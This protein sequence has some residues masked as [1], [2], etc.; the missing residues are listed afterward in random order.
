MMV[1]V[2]MMTTMTKG[3]EP[4]KYALTY[5]A[6][7]GDNANF[8]PLQ[9][10]PSLIAMQPFRGLIFTGSFLT[11]NCVFLSY[12][13]FFPLTI[14]NFQ[15]FLLMKVLRMPSVLSPLPIMSVSIPNYLLAFI[16]DSYF[17][18]FIPSVAS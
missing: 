17:A 4:H 5:L 7:S 16:K 14:Q 13:G 10:Y 15:T 3:S 6:V 12:L 11:V 8:K 1:A 18:S 9:T 2:M